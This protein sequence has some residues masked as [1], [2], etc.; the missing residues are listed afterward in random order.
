MKLIYVLLDPRDHYTCYVG[1]TGNPR[2]RLSSHLSNQSSLPYVNTWVKELRTVG[3]TPIFREIMLV[4]DEEAFHWEQYWIYD[5][6][7]RDF[8][9]L[10]IYGR[11]STKNYSTLI[12][13]QSPE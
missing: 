3:L 11:L 10:N 13:P 12:Y 6:H 1:S 9:I 5:Y 8:H 7:S 4:P 2:K